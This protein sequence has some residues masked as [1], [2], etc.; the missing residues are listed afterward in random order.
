MQVFLPLSI[1]FQGVVVLLFVV[2][3][4]EMGV[5]VVVFLKGGLHEF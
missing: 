5:V 1:I 2:V 3:M 4:V